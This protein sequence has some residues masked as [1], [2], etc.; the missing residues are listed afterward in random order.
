MT[1]TNISRAGLIARQ[2][3]LELVTLHNANVTSSVDALDTPAELALRQEYRA[4]YERRQK[5]PEHLFV[6]VDF[7][8]AAS[9]AA[10][11][12]PSNGAL[13]LS[14]TYLLAYRLVNPDEQPEDALQFF[15]ELN[16]VYNAWPY[17][18]ELVQ[19]VSG[20]VG[21]SAIVVPVFR[22]PSKPVEEKPADEPATP[23]AKKARK[24]ISRRKQL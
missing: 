18:R 7:R 22:P 5:N 4:W 14:A 9:D 24:T 10:G 13:D 8:F 12:E 15:A 23:P 3:E 11:E 19:T 17:W 6:Y 2:V 21:L 20:R 16:G 1:V